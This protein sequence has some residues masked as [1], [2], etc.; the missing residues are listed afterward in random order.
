MRI[1]SPWLLAAEVAIAVLVVVVEAVT[2][3]K[4]PGGS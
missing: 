2:K 4:A 3:K 1:K